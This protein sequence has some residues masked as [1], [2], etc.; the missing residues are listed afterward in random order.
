M[1]TN[2]LHSPLEQFDVYTYLSVYVIG[3][4][5]YSFT[6][7]SFYNVLAAV[8]LIGL[9]WLGD[10]NFRL[11][12]NGYSATIQAFYDSLLSIL[13]GQLGYKD[14]LDQFPWVFTLFVTILVMNWN[15]NIPYSMAVTS[16]GVVALGLS[17]VIWFGV[18]FMS[19]GKYGIKF[20]NT[21]T[22]QNVP[23]ALLPLLVAVETISYSSRAISLG[24]RLLCNIVAGHAMLYMLSSFIAPLFV[25]GVLGWT[26]GIV[27]VTAFTLL[28]V[29]EIAVSLIQSFVF[30]VLTSSYIKEATQLH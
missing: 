15:S 19:I 25:K 17:F 6:N 27:G 1:L 3:L 7:L 13:S 20:L 24:T 22:P 5:S 30:T 8:A 18:T 28:I 11:I 4:G 2:L 9:F 23:T 10:N 12:P 29:L 26:L 21:F 14:K 16:S